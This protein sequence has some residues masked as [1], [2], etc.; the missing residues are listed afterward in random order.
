[1]HIWEEIVKEFPSTYFKGPDVV[2][3]GIGQNLCKAFGVFRLT[4]SA[5]T[6]RED[7]CNFFLQE[8]DADKCLATI[9][10]FFDTVV[11]YVRADSYVNVGVMELVRRGVSELNQYFKAHA[12]GYEFRDGKII[13]VDSEF[14]HTEA[15]VPALE[16]LKAPYLAGANQ[17]F[18]AAHQHFRHQRYKECLNECLK[19]FE[20]TMKA[21][22]H[23]RKWP[24]S[25]SDTAKTLIKICEDNQLFPI[26]ME[27]H[28]TGLRMSLESGV[29]TARNKTS[30][31]G[32]GVTPITV[33][34]EFASYV[35]NLTATNIQFFASAEQK[36]K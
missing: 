36:L 7:V 33:S 8:P 16:L 13:R 23:K 20:S 9:E 17:E 34:E 3:S 5:R 1:M 19:A 27:N 10:I 31:H 6:P 30:G 29:P 11:E 12:V 14:T 2:Y 28:L 4:K 24:Y 35:L 18:L 22:C 26:F 25:Q 21:I 15:T 32:Q